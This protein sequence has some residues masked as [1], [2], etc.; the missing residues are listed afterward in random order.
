M[1]VACVACSPP[2]AQA[3]PQNCAPTTA[4][5]PAGSS[6]A[7]LEGEYRLRLI[8][9]SGPKSGDTADGVLRLRPP[10]STAPQRAVLFGTGE[11]DTEAIGG[12]AADLASED[13]GRP[14]VLVFDLPP[15]PEAPESPR[16]VMRLGA[17]ANR[18]DVTRVEGA[19][20][21][22]RVREI[23]ADGFAGDWESGAPLPSAGGYFCAVASDSAT[24]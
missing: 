23:R 2:P 17:E 3:G 11:L 21:V 12:P 24:P 9:T 7:A 15:L 20:T 4:T 14:G 16:V 10:A 6:G 18:Q 8:A 19:Y 5:L 22:L 13:P 1:L